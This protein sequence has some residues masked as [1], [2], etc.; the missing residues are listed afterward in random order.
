MGPQV[1]AD[2]LARFL[3]LSSHSTILQALAPETLGVGWL[4]VACG[5]ALTSPVDSNTIFHLAFLL[6][7]RFY[8]FLMAESQAKGLLL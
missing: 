8:P 5:R 3:N 7:W 4:A 2:L 1:T 6:R